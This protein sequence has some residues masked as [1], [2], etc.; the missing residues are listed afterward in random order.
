MKDVTILNQ[1]ANDY[2]TAELIS[3]AIVGILCIA[4]G[5]YGLKKRHSALACGYMIIGCIIVSIG[6][7]ARLQDAPATI[8]EVTV[9]EEVSLVEF[10]QKYEILEIDGEKYTV[11]EKPQEG[12]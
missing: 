11:R 9:S 10:T 7:V 8:Y 3:C 4:L 1:Y 2:R 12:K 5:V 6:I